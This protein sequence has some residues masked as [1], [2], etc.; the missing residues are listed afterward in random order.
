[1]SNWRPCIEQSNLFFI[2]D[3]NGNFNLLEKACSRILPLRKSDGIKDMIVFGGDYMDRCFDGHLVLDYL[4]ELNKKYPDQIVFIFGNHEQLVL[5]AINAMPNVNLS[6]PGQ[7]TYYKMWI[8]NGGLQTLT[9]YLKRADM[10]KIDP[11]SLLMYRVKDFIP[12]E[13][14]DFLQNKLV[15]Y[16]EKDDFWFVHGGCDPYK[17]LKDQEPE[18]LWWN[19]KLCNF[20]I[21]CIN[22][23]EQSK[24]DWSQT[25]ITGH[26]A[27]LLP[28]IHQKF[29]MTDIS[30]T[31]KE[32][33]V[34]ELNSMSAMVAHVDKDRLV[35]YELEETK[36]KKM[37]FRRVE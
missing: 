25:I 11:L 24:I 27:S 35:S 32:L 1:M 6:L 36:P 31:R 9:G 19:R 4:I 34:V 37:P 3:L 33:L 12:Q 13:H 17:P 10:E 2:P 5:S 28:I 26:N 23:N 7:T 18:E 30:A 16:Y 20:V 8:Q 22:N 29:L 15:N 21:S 14:I